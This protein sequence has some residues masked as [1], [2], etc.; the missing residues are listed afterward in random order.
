[1]KR[2]FLLTL[3]TL[4]LY[5]TGASASLCG[6]STT[7]GILSLSNVLL[8][9]SAIPNNCPTTTTLGLYSIPDPSG[10]TWNSFIRNLD[11]DSWSFIATATDTNADSRIT[12]E[13]IIW[14]LMDITWAGGLPGV[15]TGAG[16]SLISSGF[17]SVQSFGDDFL[18]IQYAA[19]D[20][21]CPQGQAGCSAQFDG[22]ITLEKRSGTVPTPAT[23]ALFGLGLAGLDWSRRR[24]V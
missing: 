2:I 14:R 15:V 13:G 8:G 6:T 16:G 20:I 24:K 1:M 9:Q 21:D 7:A 11:E 4:G 22:T 18:R 3:M 17:A 5:S 12:L 23:L 10:D 19:V